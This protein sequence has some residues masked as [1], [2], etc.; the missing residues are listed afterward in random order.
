LLLLLGLWAQF[1]VHLV[2]QALLQAGWGLVPLSF[3]GLSWAMWDVV[4][5]GKLLPSHRQWFRLLM[6]EWSSDG[7]SRLIPS[8]G[9]GGEPFRYRHLR[10]MTSEPGKLVLV[11]RI[12]H[13]LTGLM[14][15]CVT[16]WL[17]LVWGLSPQYPWAKL[18]LLSGL[19]IGVGLL[20]LLWW[21]PWPRTRLLLALIPKVVSRFVQVSEVA[22]VLI[23]LGQ[24][25]TAERVLMLQAYLAA[26]A[27]L[28]AFVPGG[29]GVQEAALVQAAVDCGLGPEVGFQIGL[30][31]RCRQLMWAGWGLLAASWLEGTAVAKTDPAGPEQSA[32]GDE[33]DARQ[34]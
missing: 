23:L 20:A 14:A 26:S 31:R 34:S 6:M 32:P 3:L 24:L 13:A 16:A 10:P 17:C 19:A 15:T 33:P 25:P 4:C 7:L 2:G 9:L 5:I 12:M 8:A 22:I 21:R 27:S 30:L 1:S 18:A 29:L 28:F 11:Y